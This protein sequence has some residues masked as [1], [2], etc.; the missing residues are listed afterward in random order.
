M[1]FSA[2]QLARIAETIGG[3]GVTDAGNSTTIDESG[4]LVFAMFLEPTNAPNPQASLG[5]TVVNAIVEAAQPP[6][7]MLHVE[8][9]APEHGKDSIFAT[10][11]GF[12]SGFGTAFGNGRDFYFG[13]NA[14]RW[15]AVPIAARNASRRTHAEC[16]HH[17]ATPY[18]LARYAFAVPPLRSVAALLPSKPHAPA[19]CATLTA[20]VLRRAIPELGLARSEAWYGP[21]TLFLELTSERQMQRTSAFLEQR[22]PSVRAQTDDE[23]KAV[24]AHVLVNGTDDEVAQLPHEAST[25]AVHAMARRAVDA[26]V[27]DTARRLV[28]RQLA[29]ALLRRSLD[30]T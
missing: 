24:A 15:R 10:Y 5:E 14:G 27:D 7:S 2:E 12:E 4:D 25:L 26:D 1:Q 13:H 6:P 16:E 22:Q 28:Q 21:A 11:L 3:D 23:A 29:T 17:V 30:T 18:S 19:H 9:L 8:L 20:R